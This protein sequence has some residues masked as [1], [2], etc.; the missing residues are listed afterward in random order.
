[1]EKYITFTVDKNMTGLTV[2]KL[3]RTNLKLTR[4]Q[5]SR[6][7]FQ[8]GGIQKNGAQCRVTETVQGGDKISVCIESSAFASSHLVSVCECAH[9]LE[10]LYEDEDI[11]AVNK[12][13]GMLTHPSGAH[14][15]DTLSNQ[16]AGYFHKKKISCRVR[17]TG[18]LDKE[19]SGIVLFAKN[20][21]SA[22]RLQA[23]RESGV[24]H[25]QYLAVV[26]GDFSRDT[27]DS[28]DTVWHTVSFPIRKTADH[29]LRMEA[30]TDFDSSFSPE[31]ATGTSSEND[32]ATLLSAV[33]HY[34]ILYNSPDLSV[35]TLKLDTGRTHQIRVHM[36]ALGHPLLG[37]TLYQEILSSDFSLGQPDFKRTALHAWK[38]RFRH[39]FNNAWI[40]LEA[41]LPD[42]FCNCFQNIDFSL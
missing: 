42:D 2:E 28:S 21:V 19:T 38:T 31:S 5:I 3:L 1:M 11:L 6:A 26:Q 17:P 40:S 41:P 39:P 30:V 14:Y 32:A 34:Q 23:Q 25:K 24:L 16:V 27:K 13:A 33:T 18:R 22:Q 20:Q 10:I 15:A 9:P 12:P 4:K 29:P 36:K 37:D 8:P 35:I 7:K